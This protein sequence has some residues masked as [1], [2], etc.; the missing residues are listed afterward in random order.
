MAEKVDLDEYFSEYPNEMAE[1]ALKLRNI[2]LE[3]EPGFGEKIKWKNLFYELNGSVCAILIH[4]T[5]INLEF[6]RGREL[7]ESGYPLEGTG[8]NIRH[9][10]IYQEDD[11][12]QDILSEIINKA[13]ELNSS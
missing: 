12:N 7:I 9:F 10:K 13:I 11:L 4:K 3:I 8:K 5:H 2:L 1:L 6:T